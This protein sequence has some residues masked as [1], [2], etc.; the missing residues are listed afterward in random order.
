M[1]VDRY[2]VIAFLHVDA[3]LGEWRAQC[4]VPIL[5]LIDFL[6]TV[7]A[8]VGFEIDAERANVDRVKIGSIAAADVGVGVRQ[9][10]D[11]LAEDVREIVAIA[12]IRKK[13]RVLVAL[14]G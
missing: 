13:L 14:L 7:E 1:A 3:G 11:K 8:I 9:L 6:E 12:E 10:S 4:C 2:Q 5:A